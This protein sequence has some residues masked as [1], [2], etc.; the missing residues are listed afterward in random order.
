MNGWA[1]I[2][3]T[4]EESDNLSVLVTV[5]A[6]KGSTPRETGTQMLVS[7]NTIIGT[8]GGGRLEYLAIEH[9]KSLL[10]RK[11]QNKTEILNL[12][13]GPELAQCCGG[14]VDVFLYRLDNEDNHWL[15]NI[16]DAL[17]SATPSV[18]LTNWTKNAVSRTVVENPQVINTIDA[19]LMQA[20]DRSL[21]SGVTSIIHNRKNTAYVTLI[22]PLNSPTFHLTLFGAGHVG[23]AVIHTLSQLPCSI[24]WID[25]RAEMFPGHL[26]QNVKKIVTSSPATQ[27][28]EAPKDSFYLV[29][30]HSHQLDFELCEKILK[31]QD[32]AYLGLIGSKTKRQKFL[33]RLKLRGFGEQQLAAL[34]CPIGLS[35]LEGKHPSQIA[36]SV[37]AEILFLVQSV[38]QETS[39]AG[40]T[41]ISLMK[42]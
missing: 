32:S 40:Q 42:M 9:A 30:T 19:A 31:R 38:R 2:I 11:H 22:E 16:K 29:M 21:K 3:R 12:P 17:I 4:H 34:T 25:E 14:H 1:D 41:D 7:N 13:L 37:S 10:N 24:S 28:E 20:I 36:I 33:K 6:V 15:E 23:K 27:I 39:V 35:H 5:G 26:P 8:I 18:L